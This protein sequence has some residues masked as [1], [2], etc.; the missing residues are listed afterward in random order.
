MRRRDAVRWS[1]LQ[2]MDEDVS[3]P[4]PSASHNHNNTTQPLLI[5]LLAKCLAPVGFPLSLY[6]LGALR[7]CSSTRL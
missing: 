1:Q 6:L 3:P 7:A 2:E 4:T 5:H